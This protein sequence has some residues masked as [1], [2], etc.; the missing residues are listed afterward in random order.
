MHLRGR[1]GVVPADRTPHHL[2]GVCVCVCV[3]VRVLQRRPQVSWT[4]A[5]GAR[6]CMCAATGSRVC[7][8]ALRARARSERPPGGLQGKA[9]DCHSRAYGSDE[10]KIVRQE[11]HSSK[12]VWLWLPSTSTKAKRAQHQQ[13]SVAVVTSSCTDAV[14][15][16]QS[17]SEQCSHGLNAHSASLPAVL[18]GG[19][20]SAARK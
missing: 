14:I 19:E 11:A 2:A 3:C 8:H 9:R 13:K 17:L 7:A 15:V 1:V 4:C 16:A 12:H 10:G 5:A 6:C 18:A 20:W